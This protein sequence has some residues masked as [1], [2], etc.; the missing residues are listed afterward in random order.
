MMVAF[1]YL[2][3]VGGYTVKGSW[4]NTKQ[5]V[6]F[7]YKDVSFFKKNNQGQLRCLPCDAPAA[8]IMMANR[9]T[10]KLDNHKN[11]WKGVCGIRTQTTRNG[12]AQS[13]HSP[14]DTPTSEKI[15]PT[16]KPSS[17]LTTME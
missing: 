7:K 16:P 13:V 14:I 12:T 6:Q 8:L 10:L 4:N 5:T 2:L 1:Y 3:R 15:T 17:P 11:G 9:A